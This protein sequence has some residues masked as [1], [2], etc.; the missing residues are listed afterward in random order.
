[1]FISTCMHEIVVSAQKVRLMTSLFEPKC[2]LIS[3]L[4]LGKRAS[5]VP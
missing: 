4:L 2:E 1:M 5:G 3:Q